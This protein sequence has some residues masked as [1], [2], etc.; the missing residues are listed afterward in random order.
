MKTLRGREKKD[1]IRPTPSSLLRLKGSL[2]FGFLDE[3][4]FHA[5]DARRNDA[6][7]ANKRT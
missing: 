4:T 2:T 5:A 3:F 6:A 1:H 7:R